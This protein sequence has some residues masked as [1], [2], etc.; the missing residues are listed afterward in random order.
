[1]QIDPQAARSMQADTGRA[2]RPREPWAHL[3]DAVLRLGGSQ[4]RLLR[5]GERPWASATFTGTRHTVAI[6]FAGA[7]AQAAGDAFIAALP[8]HEFAIPGQ[9][10]A[11]AAITSVDQVM[12]PEPLLT[13]EAQLLLLED[14]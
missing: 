1:M 6:S 3:L 8:E 2:R 10:V 14:A 5:H 13:V 7:G 9:L 4:A 11:D 12:V